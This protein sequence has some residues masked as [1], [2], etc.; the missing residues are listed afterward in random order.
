MRIAFYPQSLLPFHG[1][2]LEERPLGGTETGAIRLSEALHQLGHQVVVFTSVEN[3][4][5]SEPKYYH[6]SQARG[7]RAVDVFVAIREWIP[8][9]YQIPTRLKLFW[10]GDAPDQVHNFGIGDRR[11][12]KIV[13][14]LLTVSDWHSKVLSEESG[15]PI[16]QC[17]AIRNGIHLPY[18]PAPDYRLKQP[19]LM[20]AS[21][22]FRGLEHLVRL[23]PQIRAEVPE[24][25]LHVFSGFDVYK[26]K[27]EYSP[28]VQARY[29][30]VFDALQ[31]MEG[32]V[33]RGNVKQAEL[34]A[35][36]G[37]AKVLAYPNTFKE[38]SCIVVMEAQASGCVPVTSALGAL[39]E[40]VGEC[41]VTI[42]GLPGEGEYDKQFVTEC[43]Q[44]LKDDAYYRAFAEKGRVRAESELSWVKVAERFVQYLKDVHSLHDGR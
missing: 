5:P 30:G 40:T 42:S 15:Y 11:V 25:E 36:F 44:L 39:P 29:Q 34:A 9:V 27:T 13:H 35:E 21:T 10:T 22:P 17:F 24:A 28:D 38:T 18:F 12:A 20:Y 7:L 8:L 26:G 3:P 4:P 31:K 41:G 1:K 37:I 32:V 6:L 19:R 2:S 43:V 33:L 23:F 14:G 16:D